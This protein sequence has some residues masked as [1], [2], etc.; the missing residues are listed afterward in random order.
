MTENANER[1]RELL[2]S[3]YRAESGRILA[4]L[5]R[6]LGD[7]TDGGDRRDAGC[8]HQTRVENNRL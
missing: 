6:L 1:I 5:I 7:R 8:G 2:D 4:T 3:V